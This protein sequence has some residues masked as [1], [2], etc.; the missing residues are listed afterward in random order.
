MGSA[1]QS[2]AHHR[3][4]RRA[5]HRILKAMRPL[6]CYLI[7]R[8]SCVGYFLKGLHP[9]PQPR[10]QGYASFVNFFGKNRLSYIQFF[11]GENQN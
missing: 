9:H 10:Y 3:A 8:P 11:L 7:E 5:R 2:A 6:S 1:S 4:A